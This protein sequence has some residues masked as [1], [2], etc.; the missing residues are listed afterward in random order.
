MKLYTRTELFN[1]VGGGDVKTKNFTV[2]A[3]AQGFSV[4]NCSQF[5]WEVKGNRVGD[6]GII[7]PYTLQM[8]NVQDDIIYIGT[9]TNNIGV[10][11]PDTFVDVFFSIHPVY[12]GISPLSNFSAF[13]QIVRNP[14]CGITYFNESL[15]EDCV[16]L[17]AN[18][19]Y[20]MLGRLAYISADF[21]PLDADTTTVKV[22]LSVGNGNYY[23]DSG[24]ISMSLAKTSSIVNLARSFPG[25]GVEV[26]DNIYARMIDG[27]KSMRVSGYACFY[28]TGLTSL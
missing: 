27:V 10:Q 21:M 9:K 1:K 3:Y 18:H 23:M 20:T 13:T 28:G 2:P 25:G 8:F 4:Y 17:I 24:F 12:P 5:S 6:L 26:D 19:P 7:M 14:Q 11:M 16:M 22:G 15:T